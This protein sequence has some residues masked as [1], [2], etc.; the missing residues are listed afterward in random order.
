M[1]FDTPKILDAT[2]GSR[3]IWLDEH[4]QN[5]IQSMLIG[6]NKNQG[7]PMRETPMM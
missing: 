1:T 2:C 5:D 3:S 4:K 6:E 7:L